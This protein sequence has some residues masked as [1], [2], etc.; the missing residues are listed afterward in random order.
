V[1][2]HKYIANCGY[3]S[4]RRAELLIQ[5]GRVRVNGKV[6]DEVGVS[7]E[8]ERDRVT[9]NGDHVTPPERLTIMLHKLPGFITS[10]H[11]THERLTVMD[12]L[13]RRM[14]ELGVMP[15]GRLD[16]DTTGLLLLSNDGDLNHRI[17]HPR[18]EI[19]KEYSVEAAGDVPPE[20]VRRL[21]TG[22]ELDDGMTAPARVLQVERRA[23]ATRLHL[24][25]SEGRKRQVKR[26]LEAVGY[27]VK[28]LCRVRIGGL[29]LGKLPLGEWRKLHPGEIEAVTGKDGPGK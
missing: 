19:E 7:I 29:M 12:L 14:R 27:P 10:T 26:M 28:D 9:I 2:L 3:T 24:V 1:R 8:P 25:I 11:D 22:V 15:V 5:A 17:T 16:Q 23:G 6:V 20:V 18:Y 21:E 13:P 4:R